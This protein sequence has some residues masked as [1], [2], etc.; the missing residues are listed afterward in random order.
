MMRIVLGWGWVMFFKPE[1]GGTM[2]SRIKKLRN[3]LR[4]ELNI[5]LPIVHVVDNPEFLRDAY[6][7]YYRETLIEQS[8]LP[9]SAD[10]VDAAQDILLRS[11]AEIAYLES[12][13]KP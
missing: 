3:E 2:L 7:I 1:C 9:T 11:I 6:A 10:I 13:D 5:E 12:R 4:L 8:E